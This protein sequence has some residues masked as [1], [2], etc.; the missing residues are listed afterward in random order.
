MHS[1]RED[2]YLRLV[3]TLF[4]AEAEMTLGDLANVRRSLGTQL[5]SW[6]ISC[7]QSYLVLTCRS[8]AVVRLYRSNFLGANRSLTNLPGYSV[9]R[10][11]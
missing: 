5:G 1:C 4:W 2:T 6:F 7:I 11:K 8:I 3:T 9:S 10:V